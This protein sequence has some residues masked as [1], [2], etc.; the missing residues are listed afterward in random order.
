[1]EVDLSK[2]DI[3]EEE[4][5]RQE[6]RRTLFDGVFDV[7]VQLAHEMDD[8]E[9]IDN[10]RLL[11][12]RIS[13]SPEEK[14]LKRTW[15]E[16]YEVIDGQISIGKAEPIEQDNWWVSSADDK[17]DFFNFGDY[18]ILHESAPDIQPI[19]Q[20]REDIQNALGC[21]HYERLM[22]DDWLFDGKWEALDE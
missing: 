3:S 19:M 1:M 20:V 12:M 9:P 18:H 2:S 21:A 22:S 10:N 15:E 17:R 14:E 6:P 11:N 13:E 7:G 8:E 5:V 4:E 16:E